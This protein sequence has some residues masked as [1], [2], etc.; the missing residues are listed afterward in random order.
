MYLGIDLG[1]SEVKAVVIDA[2]GKLLALAGSPL[3]VSRPTR[4][5]RSRSRSTGGAPLA[6]PS[7]AC[8]NNWERNVSPAS[9]R[10]ACPGR[11]TARSC[12]MRGSACCVRPSCGAIRAART[13]APS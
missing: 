6:T 3:T 12:W 10:S 11:C 4:A 13:N 5:G 9:A 8:A 1:T 2:E 7:P